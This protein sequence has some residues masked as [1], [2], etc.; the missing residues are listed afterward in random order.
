MSEYAFNHNT[1]VITLLAILRLTLF[2]E[3]LVCECSLTAAT[4]S[5]EPPSQSGTERVRPD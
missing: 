1:V 3:S 5:T 2:V 4:A